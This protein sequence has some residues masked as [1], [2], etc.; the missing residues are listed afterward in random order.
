MA[1]FSAYLK[2]VSFV[3]DTDCPLAGPTVEK[4]EH[5]R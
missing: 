5:L 4:M 2:F 1:F 3:K